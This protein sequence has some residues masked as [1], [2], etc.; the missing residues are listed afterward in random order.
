MITISKHG[1]SPI[2]EFRCEHCEC[3]FEAHAADCFFV[4]HHRLCYCPECGFACE[5][6]TRH[7]TSDLTVKEAENETD[8]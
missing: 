4:E 1:N 7:D 3:E 6:I 2:G 5:A 8:L